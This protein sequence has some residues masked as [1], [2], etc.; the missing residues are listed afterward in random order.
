M[1][2]RF[3]NTLGAEHETEKPVESLIIVF[4]DLDESE[5]EEYLVF[6]KQAPGV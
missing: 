5:G 1:E 3:H 4:P 6:C 2:L